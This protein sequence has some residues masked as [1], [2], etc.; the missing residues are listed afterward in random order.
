MF[1]CIVFVYTA[2]VSFRVVLQ[3]TSS[4]RQPTAERIDAVLAAS[5]EEATQQPS[6]TSSLCLVSLRLFYPIQ[7]SR[8]VSDAGLVE[9]VADWSVHPESAI[10]ILF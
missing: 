6:S 10:S 4:K 3:L 7:H 1:F 9:V 2:Y 5:L 8:R